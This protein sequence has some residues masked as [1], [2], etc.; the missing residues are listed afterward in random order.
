MNSRR[1]PGEDSYNHTYPPYAYNAQ[2]GI[3]APGEFIGCHLAAFGSQVVPVLELA[4]SYNRQV[5]RGP[6]D[7]AEVEVQ[8]IELMR[9]DSWLSYVGRLDGISNGPNRLLRQTPALVDLI[10]QEFESDLGNLDRPATE[11]GTQEIQSVAANLMD[12]LMD[13]ELTEA[14]QL[15][16]YPSYLRRVS[17]HR[18]GTFPKTPMIPS[19]VFF[20]NSSSR[21]SSCILGT[22]AS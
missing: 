12:F 8:T 5:A 2:G 21:V 3:I 18:A 6:R 1:G 10:M 15:Y 7:V 17:S 13:E 16:G 11:G 4:H 9:I 14:E 22:F 20:T 19:T